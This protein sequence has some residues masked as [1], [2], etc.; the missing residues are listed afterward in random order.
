[1]NVINLLCLCHLAEV[2][3]FCLTIHECYST[4]D[5]QYLPL[6]APGKIMNFGMANIE[7][8]QVDIQLEA[9]LQQEGNGKQCENEAAKT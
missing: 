2:T 7:S 9:C 5:T 1:M 8:K 4:I 6:H 3:L